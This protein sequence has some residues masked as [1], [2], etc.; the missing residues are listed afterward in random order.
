[1]QASGLPPMRQYLDPAFLHQYAKAGI[2]Q[3]L[4]DD[5][6]LSLD[7]D[8]ISIITS[9][10]V[11]HV[12]PEPLP[13]TMSLQTTTR[14]LTELAIGNTAPLDDAHRDKVTARDS[15]G[16]LV[17]QLTHDYL[18]RMVRWLDI[19]KHYQA[20]LQAHLQD[21][22]EGRERERQYAQ[23]LAAQL[24]LDAR[25]AMIRRDINDESRNWVHAALTS[26]NAV[27]NG[28]VVQARQ[29]QIGG[30]TLSGI[31]LFATNPPQPPQRLSPNYGAW[32]WRAG[33]ANADTGTAK[34]VAY[35]PDAPDGIRLREFGCRLD[36]RDS[37]INNPAMRDYLLQHVALDGRDKVRNILE[38]PTPR[39]DITDNIVAG[40][41][42]A[43][44]YRTRVKQIIADADARTISN[45]EVQHQARQDHLNMAL[46]IAGILLPAKLTVPLSLGRAFHSFRN[47][48][49]AAQRGDKEEALSGFINAIE[50]LGDALTDGLMAR[51]QLSSGLQHSQNAT[52][53]PSLPHSSAIDL[54]PLPGS[55][56]PNAGNLDTRIANPMSAMPAPLQSTLNVPAG[57]SSVEIEGST[58]YYWNSADNLVAWRD[59]FERDPAHPN[60]LRSAGYGAPDAGNV[61]RKLALRGGGGGQSLPARI[62]EIAPNREVQRLV[63]RIPGPNDSIDYFP[64][65]SPTVSA[66]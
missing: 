44:C 37:F 65:K 49:E 39:T 61:W 35:T 26:R 16:Y 60:Q 40:N 62:T 8:D 25:E 30:H 63:H 58:F 53:A 13:T 28:Q 57:M 56:S 54:K 14:T 22:A 46:D 17:P 31:L 33:Q 2:Q 18:T 41:F 36:M 66:G 55:S 4:L 5:L 3:Q 64:L 10:L 42:L 48:Q 27:T 1:M 6:Q 19:G 12:P 20:M 34:I 43:A 15:D 23:F 7:P 32:T 45:A 51:K 59:L 24:Q 11:A 9:E 29:L 47:S 21:S 38:Q 50:H 52:S